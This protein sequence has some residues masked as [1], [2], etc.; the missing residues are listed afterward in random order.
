MPY[1]LY[2]LQL[3]YAHATFQYIGQ[4]LPSIMNRV[5]PVNFQAAFKFQIVSL[6][7]ALFA[8]QFGVESGFG[9]SSP[10]AGNLPLGN[11]LFTLW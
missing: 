7:F 8:S 4:Y 11:D 1:L 9:C 2:C 6:H 3:G 10:A 5:P